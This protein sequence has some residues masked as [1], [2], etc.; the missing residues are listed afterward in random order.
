MINDCK[1]KEQLKNYISRNLDISNV[2]EKLAEVD[3][4]KHLLLDREEIILLELIKRP[5][6]RERISEDKKVADYSLFDLG[7]KISFF[8]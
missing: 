4:I 7:S 1:I 6:I 3:L 5:K 8:H 2:I